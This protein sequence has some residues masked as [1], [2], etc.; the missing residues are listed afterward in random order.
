MISRNNLIKI[1]NR[2]LISAFTLLEILIVIGILSTLATVVVYV[3]NPAE[4]LKQSRDAKRL[5][6]IQTLDDAVRFYTFNSG[7]LDYGTSSVVYLSLPDSSTTCSSYS[8]LPTLTGGWTYA[9]KPESTYRK[10]DGT[11]W[12]PVNFPSTQAGSSLSILPVDPTNNNT[13]YYSYIPGS[14]VLTAKIE[15]AKYLPIAQTDGG[16]DSARFEIGSNLALWES[17]GGG[18]TSTAI[19]ATGGTITTDGS[20]TIHTFATSGTFTVT[21]SGSVETLVVAGGGGGGGG[22]NSMGGGGGAGGVI[23]TTTNVTS[24]SYA[25]TVGGGGVG[26]LSVSYGN[27]SS[28]QNSTALNLTALGGGYG[29]SPQCGDW[30]ATYSSGGN[31]GSGGGGRQDNYGGYSTGGLG[32]PGQGY[33]GGAGGWSSGG[34]GGGATQNGG[35]SGG[36]G[37]S[38]Y[39]SSI[40]GA[41]ITYGGGGGGAHAGA[42]GTGGGGSV[43]N[44]G[45][46]NTGGGGGGNPGASGNGGS[47]GSGIVIIRY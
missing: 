13:Y 41:S 31:G 18:S 2:N 19:I 24:Q 34:G 20:Y 21:G 43:G 5:S 38:G 27:G 1:F 29:A 22:C 47:G 6:E 4:L 46:P 33:N 35:P 3:L 9:C 14:W 25:I 10:V 37:G 23:A 36:N 8:N 11:G 39:T 15:S 12:I 28:G 40:S 26:G 17:S 44:N 7:T 42:G 45:S 32:T 30:D 16:S